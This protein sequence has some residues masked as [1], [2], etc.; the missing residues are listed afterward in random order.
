MIR[1]RSAYPAAV[2]SLLCFI[3]TAPWL[4]AAQTATVPSGEKDQGREVGHSGIISGRVVSEDGQP[5]ADVGVSLSRVSSHARLAERHKLYTDEEGRFQSVGLTA[6][7]Y[8]IEVSSSVYV[9]PD[10][11]ADP[12]ARYYYPGD[13][14]TITLVRGGV[15]T[16]KV[17][18][19]AG[20]P[21]IAAGVRA[22]R[23]GGATA[24]VSVRT[25]DRGVYRI[26]GLRAGAYVV[27]TGGNEDP[28]G[29]VPYRS[30]TRTYYPSGPRD[31]AAEVR[32]G[33]GEEIAGIDIR[34][35]GEQ[36][37]RVSGTVRVSGA[38]ERVQAYR[39]SL[40][41]AAA[42]TIE[43]ANVRRAGDGSAGF[44][45]YGVADGEY[46]VIAMGDTGGLE[47]F[48]S[49][50]RRITVSGA[51]VTGIELTLKPLS[52]ISGRAILETSSSPAGG[53]QV[54]E[55][56]STRNETDGTGHCR[57]R[58]ESS[59]QQVAI[60]VQREGP[61]PRGEYAH[62]L[63]SRGRSATPDEQGEFSLGSLAAGRYHLSMQAPD[64]TWYV[65]AMT[66]VATTAKPKTPAAA[67]SPVASNLQAGLVIGGGDRVSDLRITLS[68]GAAMVTGHVAAA[69]GNQLPSAVRIYLIPAEKQ[70]ADE[71]FRYAETFA[72]RDGTF[73][74]K[75]L[76]PGKYLLLATAHTASGA[77]DSA[78][79]LSRLSSAELA[80]LRRQAEESNQII[81][82]T[83]CGRVENYRLIYRAK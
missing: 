23:V 69:A 49:S 33:A 30:D 27:Y 64:E 10:D 35:R 5:L 29:F 70:Q 45:L 22:V 77:D 6:G 79:H 1:R 53:D 15:I 38:G 78:L 55:S 43:A 25:D 65:K 52:V 18:T 74:L 47:S 76:A 82:L 42:G 37:H 50:A 72:G 48:L 67:G 51:D 21:V 34:H 68:E 12:S 62:L 83:R 3:S 61:E 19:V 31:T 17:T 58:P 14:A 7:A 32:V 11:R 41:S 26:F 66:R 8:Q 13:Q 36:G 81:E 71:R 20:D 75:N 39:I 80:T 57:G 16:G 60:M 54:K 24:A 73:D 40:I 59:I 4:A 2:V 63:V 9:L 46:D 44:G 56:S 28:A